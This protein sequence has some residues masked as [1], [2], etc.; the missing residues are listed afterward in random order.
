MGLFSG[1]INKIE[2]MNRK[3]DMVNGSM[4]SSL[5][6]FALPLFF[7]SL[8]QMLYNTE[9][10]SFVGNFVGK[11]AAAAVGAGS[12]LVTCLIGIFTGLSVGAGVA[13]AQAVGAGERK[14]LEKILHTSVSTAVIGG[15]AVM[16]TGLL[17][18]E[19]LLRAMHTP[20]SV[21]E[22]AVAYIQ[23]YFISMVPMIVYNMGAGIL[24]AYGDSRTP[25][26]IL[27]AGGILNIL[28]DGLLVGV[29][30]LGVRGA[31][32]ATVVSQ[33]FSA[34]VILHVLIKGREGLRLELRKLKINK[35]ELGRILH[36][37]VPSGIQSVVITL[38]NIIIQYY[39]NGYGANAVAVFAVYFKLENFLYLPAV[40][41]GQAATTFAGQNAGAGQ[42]KRIQRGIF[43]AAGISG[44]TV[45][46]IACMLL[47]GRESIF[48]WFIRDLDV[49]L[50]GAQI[51][52]ITF[53][54]YWLYP[55]MEVL[56]GAIR[57]MGYS[58]TPM[59]VILGTLCGV[60]ISILDFL[61]NRIQDI[62]AI[63]VVYPI[64]WFLAALA[65]G[66]IFCK[67]V[68]GKYDKKKIKYIF[69]GR[70]T[71]ECTR[72]NRELVE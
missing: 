17:L 18:S 34:I 10:L 19:F 46:V 26:Y 62:R 22:D 2:D 12:L 68:R 60:R 55:I 38:S 20:A 5:F 48:L 67:I 72:E 59:L 61:N 49:A 7:S 33:F 15:A 4:G 14:R 54:F 47:L 36:L 24:R 42:Y 21:M 56:G 63:A 71:G 8:L 64:T 40:A 69:G 41:F 43:L 16:L 66:V 58:I 3:T 45:A 27:A 25:F 11:Q 29:L 52:M 28:T 70:N 39:I 23:I 50:Y 31:A 53:P 1:R 32:G 51:I 44:C 57:G 35:E 30:R 37:G 65:Y 6:L 13:A 9:D